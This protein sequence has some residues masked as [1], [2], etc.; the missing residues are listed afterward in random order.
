MLGRGVWLALDAV[1]A[2]AADI[3]GEPSG[4]FAPARP[5]GR[6]LGEEFDR[7]DLEDLGE[8]DQVIDVDA[9]FA[10]LYPP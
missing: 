10:A 8:R 3:A 2:C 5:A 9:T 7:F 1:G 6:L 4:W